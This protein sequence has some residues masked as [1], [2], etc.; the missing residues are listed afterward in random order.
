MTFDQHLR[1]GFVLGR[2]LVGEY[3][4]V[5]CVESPE[6]SRS[7][8]F[9]RVMVSMVNAG[10]DHPLMTL[11]A[12]RFAGQANHGSATKEPGSLIHSSLPPI[13]DDRVTGPDRGAALSVVP[14]ESCFMWPLTGVRTP[15]EGVPSLKVPGRA[16]KEFQRACRRQTTGG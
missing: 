14:D 15:T 9:R 4:L 16:R 6:Q 7:G 1:D 13:P 5:K 2:Y 12:T 11:C 8:R 3:D 10:A